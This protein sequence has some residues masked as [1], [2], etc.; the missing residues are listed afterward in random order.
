METLTKP[1]FRESV[2]ESVS[3]G[4]HEATYQG[5]HPADEGVPIKAHSDGVVCIRTRSRAELKGDLPRSIGARLDLRGKRRTEDGNTENP[6]VNNLLAPSI[7]QKKSVKTIM[8]EQYLKS[9]E[10][11]APRGATT[12]FEHDPQSHDLLRGKAISRQR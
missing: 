8:Q 11:R 9:N 1:S 4:W 7:S 2:G 3:L 5:H 12:R 6:E 10:A